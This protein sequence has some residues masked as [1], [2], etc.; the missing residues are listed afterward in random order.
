MKF[1]RNWLQDYIEDKLSDDEVIIDSLNKKSFEVEGREKL[2]NGDT[3]FDIKVLPNR[4]HDALG[5]YFMAREICAELDLNFKKEERL[6]KFDSFD[7][8]LSSVKVSIEEE[9]LC[10]RFMALRV[11]GI[12]VGDSPSWLKDRL[13]SIG[14][15]SINNIVDLTNYIQFSINKPMHAY[16]ASTIEGGLCARLA[17][18]DEQI[19]TLDGKEIKL[20][21][22]TLIISDD[23]KPLALAGI[24][25]GKNSGINEKTKEIII[26]S[27]NF[28]PTNIRKT[29]QKYGIKTESSKRFE[30]GISNNLVEDGIHLMINIIKEIFPKAKVSEI[31]DIYPKKET[32]YYVP[33]SKKEINEILGSSYEEKDIE[34]A[35]NLLNFRFEK[36]IPKKYIEENYKR[37]VGAKYKNPSNMRYDAPDAFSCSSLV[38]YLY[39][40]V[41]M[42]SISVDKYV[43]A[44]KVEKKDLSFGD[45][46]FA[47]SGEGKIYTESIE[48]IR[49]QE[50]K[51]GVDHV[52]IYL[53]E[54]QILHATKKEGKVVIEDM[55]S[56]IKTRTLVGFG[57]VCDDLEEERYL[58]YVPSERLDIRKKEDIGEEI[59]R[60]IGYD[61]LTKTLPKLN[62]KGSLSKDVFVE[63]K[64]RESLIDSG[65]S[66]IMTYSFGNE[67]EL[68]ILKGLASDKE[69]LRNNLAKG[70]E[71]AISLNLY[72]SPLLSLK[73]IKVFEIGSVFLKDKEE[74][75]LA[76]SIDDGQKKSNF[77]EEID[78]YIA[79]IKRV[80][81]L[82]KVEYENKLS[83]PCIVEINLSELFDSIEDKEFYE[84]SYTETNNINLYKRVS[85][86]PFIAR[87]IAMWV[88]NN[89]SFEG[90]LSICGEINNPLVVNIYLFDTF[91]KEIDGIKKISYAF[92]LVFQSF[93]KTLTDEEVNVHMEEYYKAFRDRGYE[94]R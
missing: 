2:S 17:K 81:G 42:P 41:W 9:K 75:H 21:T 51:E 25:G 65:F 76:I 54:D 79:Q 74:R 44:N 72:N 7:K 47:N 78:L 49:G 20:N 14:E 92:R 36:I 34:G 13:E 8:D 19:T 12:K 10:T 70:V 26:E 62:R 94:I 53:G 45:L 73:K 52:G 67:G 89:I 86:Y 40:G 90:I 30:N 46:I 6:N 1:S 33:F 64:I 57:R 58:V 31:T 43:F 48:F 88:P 87:D 11:S 91:E 5:H 29:S 37:T 15:K 83:K 68:E 24:K 59:G 38:S 35:L 61:K 82:E 4:A 22:K 55:D 32:E 18:S 56:F 16:D 85:S 69:K 77:S 84:S 63:N 27:A 28:E 66:E 93:E 23:K 80:L 50:V 39:K 3:I 60:I 71:K